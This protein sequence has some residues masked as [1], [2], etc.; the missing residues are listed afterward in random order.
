VSEQY[1]HFDCCCQ[2]GPVAAKDPAAPWTVEDVLRSMDLCGIDAALVVHRLAISNDPVDA[3]HRL[4]EDLKAAPGRFFPAWVLLPD[5]V[6][7]FE[8]PAAM[9]EAMDAENVRAVKLYPARHQYALG[10]LAPALRALEQRQVLTMIDV[11]ELPGGAEGL[12]R[13]MSELLICCPELPVLLQAIP[14]SMQRVI[15]GLMERH[16]NL[17]I[18]FSTYQIN[19]GLEEYVR[20]FGAERLL[21]GTGLP[22]MSA[23]AARAYVDYAMLDDDDRATIA[24]GNLRR[25]LGGIELKAGAPRIDDA[26]QLQAARGEPLND[27]CV[28]D[29]HCHILHEG[30]DAAG[31]YVMMHGDADGLVEIKDH[32]GIQKTAIMSWVGPIGG[33]VSEGNEI[34]ARAIASYPDRFWGLV[35]VNPS[36]QSEEAMRQEIR[37]RVEEQGFVGIKPYLRQAMSYTDPLYRPCW[38]YAQEHHLYALMHTGAEAGGIEAIGKLAQ[39]YPDVQWLVAHTG[40]SF[41]LARQVAALMKDY[42]NVWAELTLT[43]VT[44]G[45]IEWL[46]AEVGDDRILFGTDAPMRDPRPQFGWVVWAGL[47]EESR[48]KILGENFQ[49]LIG[50]I[51]QHRGQHR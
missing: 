1:P 41:A 37:F 17:H 51:L 27:T 6:G 48:R 39:S 50:G 20:R 15:V 44:N 23:G 25:L 36:H 3:R 2:I 8:A 9:V 4:K 46:V 29:A 26:L 16:P 11:A 35:Y 32:V 45:V 24:G 33:D 10:Q 30:G 43:P 12:F 28:L 31:G 49:R 34:V 7:D 19:R 47:S 38:E 42:P 21:F 14:W 40:G 5:T 13:A 18:E 22:A